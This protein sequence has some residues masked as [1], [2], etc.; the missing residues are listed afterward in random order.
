M[1][2]ETL[3]NEM[4]KAM[5]VGDKERKETISALIGAAKNLAIANKCKDNITEDIVDKAIVKEQKTVKEQIETCPSDRTE[6][7]GKYMARYDVISEF[8]PKMMSEEE[9]N[10]AVSRLISENF[11][12]GVT[13]K[14][15]G[16][17]MKVVMAELK[18]KA[19]GKAL[20][21]CVMKNIG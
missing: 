1:K 2:I 3:Q 15:K 8:A 12:N 5:K 16:A 17:V 7:L 10:E 14:D 21:A 19:D 13:A 4:I 20:N 6:L 9:M 11:P 18:G